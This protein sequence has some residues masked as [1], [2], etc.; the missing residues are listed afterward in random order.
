MLRDLQVH[1]Q[2]LIQRPVAAP[3]MNAQAT[4]DF[5]DMEQFSTRTTENMKI[6]GALSV[7]R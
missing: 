6:F 7:R 5:P 4:Y 1:P 3:R 2:L